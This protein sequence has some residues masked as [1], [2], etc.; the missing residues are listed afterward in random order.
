MLMR[1]VRRKAGRA[2]EAAAL[3]LRL[4][5]DRRSRATLLGCYAAIMRDPQ[6]P[7]EVGLELSP[8]A[9]RFP[10]RMRRSD[11]FTVAEIFHEG[12]YAIAS[13]VASNPVILDC[14]AN[15]GLSAIWFLSRYPGARVHCFE[16]EP[17]N[18]RLLEHNLR[19]SAGVVLNRAAVGRAAGRLPLTLSNSAAMHSLVGQMGSDTIDAR[20]V[21][22]DVVALPEYLSRHALDAVDILK[23][24]VEGSELDVIEGMAG[25]LRSVKIIV[26]ELHEAH[27][28]PDVFFRH[29]ERQ[30]FRL[31]R[32]T[33][34]GEA[35]VRMFEAARSPA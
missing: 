7:L 6:D 10:V 32:Q 9:M 23:L 31:V 17:E 16:P 30:G 22:V 24:D 12:Q 27:V 26:G 18:F 3:T 2:L 5:K 29:L 14:G 33:R 15:I 28:D 21:E 20:R 34:T 8:G 11:V 19:G 35:D 4:T 13:P 1:F 25:R